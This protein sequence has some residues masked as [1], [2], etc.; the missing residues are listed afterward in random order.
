MGGEQRGPVV[1][2]QKSSL[3]KLAPKKT[4]PK[5]APKKSSPKK[6]ALV[7]GPAAPASASPVLELDQSIQFIKGVGPRVAERFATRGITTVEDLIRFLPRRYEDR[8]GG[9]I[10]NLEEGVHA[11]VEGEIRAKSFR[12]FRGK[13]TLD[14]TIDDGTGQ[15]TLKWFRVPGQAFGDQFQR[16][17][18]VR[19]SGA[20]TRFRRQF[21]MVHPEIRSLEGRSDVDNVTDAMVPVYLDVDG[22][23]PTQVRSVLSKALRSVDR[24]QEVLPERLCD[25][26]QL[27]SLAEAVASLHLPPPGTSLDALLARSTPWHRRLIYEE[28]FVLQLVVQRRRLRGDTHDGLP[29]PLKEPLAELAQSMFGFPLTGAQARVLGEIGEDLGST[30]PMHR[31]LQ[32][33]VGSGK[34]A[35]AM[36]AAAGCALAGFQAAVM[37]PTELLAEQH[38]RVALDTLSPLGIS[39]VVLTGALSA[40][41]RR[42]ALTQIETG[43]AQVVVGT[44]AVIQESVRFHAL[45]LGIVDEQHRF[46]VMQRARFVEQGRESTGKAPHILVMT[47]TPIPRTLALTVYGDLDLSIIDE[48]PPGRTPIKTVLY[49]DTLREQVYGR[50]RDAVREGRQAYVVL[51]LVEESDKEGMDA[52]RD[53]TTT[54]EEL[55]GGWLHGLEVGLLHGRMAADEKDEV[56]R[57]FAE[58]SVQVLVATTVIEVGIDVP[59]ATVMVVEHAERFGLSQ[60]HQLRGRVGR[61]AHRSECLLVSKHTPSEDAWR[62]LSIMEQTTDGFKIA[63]EDLAIRGPGD[64]VG[65]R[66]S[67]LPAL[68]LANLVRDQEILLQARDDAIDVLGRDSELEAPE[69][70]GL[71]KLL[72]KGWDNRLELAQIG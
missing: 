29:L 3:K 61:G 1:V 12:A 47:A 71:R 2:P 58:G 62:R 46:G 53:A 70:F 72:E 34:T 42:E 68:L 37:A 9:D 26:R 69:H 59:N 64:F 15:L 11:T 48:L 55:S 21:Q 23:A 40:A 33:D 27:V 31:L 20:V 30:M 8:R 63:E 18:W 56:M 32:G 17:C 54:A 41:A 7:S 65:T 5:N 51:P 57:A 25:E 14:M 24:M 16:R 6:A 38:A 35:V 39:V 67:G 45:A 10:A 28:L 4:P 19:V 49:K 22:M 66:Q 36:A 50:V 60:L 52:I 13:R 43:V 44:H